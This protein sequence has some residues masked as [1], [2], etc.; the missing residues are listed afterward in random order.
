MLTCVCTDDL[1]TLIWDSQM[2]QGTVKTTMTTKTRPDIRTITRLVPPSGNLVQGQSELAI[3]PELAR[4][5]SQMISESHNHS[6][7]SEGPKELRT[8]V[9][10]KIATIYNIKVDPNAVPLELMITP[11]A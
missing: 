6:C 8:V 11:G 9:P 7:P 5:A 1:Q 3:N 2:Q 10:G 4:I